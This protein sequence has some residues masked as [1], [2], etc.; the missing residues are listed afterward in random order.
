MT[1]NNPYI[2]LVKQHP[3][4]W[5]DTKKMYDMPGQWEDF[6]LQKN[7]IYLEIGTGMGNFFGGEVRENPGINYIGMELK[8]KRLYTTAQK[9]LGQKATQFYSPSMKGVG[10]AKDTTAHFVLLK[11]YAQHINTIFTEAEIDLS[12]IF[13]PDP[14]GKKDRQKKHRLLQTPFLNDIYHITK[15]A[16][17]CIIKTD[18][19]EYFDFIHTQVVETNWEVMRIS[20]DWENEDDYDK[21]K[22]TEFQKITKKENPKVHYLELQ[23]K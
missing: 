6:F 8:Y 20:Y 7:P 18:H 9:A 21:S 14:W 11:D 16:G 3:H 17:K 10:E 1:I 15:P 4:I 13:F 5:T 19:R 22:D 23:K 2:D 12:Y